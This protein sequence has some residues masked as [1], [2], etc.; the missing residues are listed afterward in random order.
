MITL[1]IRNDSVLQLL[2]QTP[3][4]NKDPDLQEKKYSIGI[5]PNLVFAQLNIR[6]K[7]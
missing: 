7:N 1:L 3:D 5:H 4:R 6:R 2:K